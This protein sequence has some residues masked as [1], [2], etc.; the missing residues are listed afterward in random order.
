MKQPSHTFWSA[1]AAE[2]LQ[3]LQ[4]TPQGL[5]EEEAQERLA[6]H[7]SNLL[8]PKKRTDDLT[9]LLSQFKSPII[10]IL[11][12]AVGISILLHDSAD[13]LII[14]IIVRVIRTRRPFYQSR[15]G[16]YLLT[17]TLIIAGVTLIL[18]FSPL[19]SLFKFRPLPAPFFIALGAIMLL[20]IIAAEIAKNLFYKKSKF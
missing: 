13:A 10:L 7:G 17:A 20:Y 2:I 8:K 12:F 9:L 18:P 14:L 1:P 16:K 15:P 19:G 5:S 3:E 11:L 4:T 6:R